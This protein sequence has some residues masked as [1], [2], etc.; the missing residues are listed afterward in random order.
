MRRNVS[1]IEI[2]LRNAKQTQPSESQ[3]SSALSE[4]VWQI[5]LDVL[6]SV[7]D[8]AMHI[9]SPSSPKDID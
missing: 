7:R 4:L 2:P 8:V 9:A 1:M 3:T 6:E 5:I